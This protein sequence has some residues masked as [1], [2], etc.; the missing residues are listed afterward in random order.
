MDK[1]GNKTEFL[2]HWNND[3]RYSIALKNDLVQKIKTDI[4]ISLTIIK[5]LRQTEL[6]HYSNFYII[7]YIHQELDKPENDYD[8]QRS[9]D[10]YN[11]SYGYDDYTIEIVFDGDQENYW[12]ID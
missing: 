5:N 11:G 9:Y 1:D 6:G 4:D 12:N 10:N 7:E 2:R 3:F 8:D